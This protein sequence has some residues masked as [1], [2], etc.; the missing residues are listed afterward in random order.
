DALRA[1]AGPEPPML[2]A[3]IE[4]PEATQDLDAI[5]DAA[6]GVMVARG[7]L[8]VRLPLEDVPHIQK[9]IIKT[10]VR[11]GRPVITATQMLESMVSASTPTRAEVTDVANAVLD[12]SSALMLSAETTIG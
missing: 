5:V 1:A 6:D 8:G 10:A 4:T 3:K 7:D 12:G 9:R 11:F 2:V